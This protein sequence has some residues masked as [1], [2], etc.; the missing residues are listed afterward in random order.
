M[1]TKNTITTGLTKEEI[2]ELVFNTE[3]ELEKLIEIYK[4][5]NEENDQSITYDTYSIRKYIE[6]TD[7]EDVVINKEV[8]DIFSA[9]VKIAEKYYCD[10]LV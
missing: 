3:R 9:A 8:D 2:S 5:E 4:E 10:G 6:T 7:D 1:K